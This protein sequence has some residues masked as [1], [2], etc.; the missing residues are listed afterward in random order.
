MSPD[1]PPLA[2]PTDAEPP[3]GGD[4]RSHLVSAAAIAVAVAVLVAVALL[5]ST[6]SFRPPAAAPTPTPT[7]TDEPSR[8]VPPDLEGA[9]TAAVEELLTARSQAILA[10]DPAAWLAQVDPAAT[11]FAASQARVAKRLA[12]VPFAQWDYQL[13]GQGPPLTPE[14]EAVLPEGAAI[15]RVRLTYRIEDTRTSTD[16]EQYLT[17][18]PRDGRWLLAGDDD[19]DPSGFET[20]QDLWDL[21]PVLVVRGTKS[22]VLGDRR[23]ASRARMERLAREADAAVA[24]VDEVWTE[25]WSR[26]PVVVLPRSQ[27]DMATLIGDDGKGLA[28]IAAV[29]TG[30]VEDGQARGDRVVINP[31]AFD[32]LGDVGRMVVLAHE[33]THVATRASTVVAPPIWLSEGFADYVAYEAASVP[34]AIVASDVLDDVRDGKAP[35]RLPEQAD[36]DAGEGDIAAAYEGA[37][38]ACRLI[39]NRYGE[40]SLVRLYRAVSDSEGP[41]W[42]EETKEVLGINERALVRA[43]KA[44]LRDTARS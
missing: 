28:Q 43:W 41:G 22:T 37:W 23:G 31:A 7:A 24:D 5:W 30:A 27:R 33:M 25:E 11:D 18:V 6:G 34:L 17:V 3:G 8:D 1:S 13:I 21:G 39:V 12:A 19:A 38:L 26:R 16:R 10:A 35:R 4:R 44:Y 9:R 14:R 20:Q 36:F 29:T 2:S 15:V 32:T 42:P 40:K